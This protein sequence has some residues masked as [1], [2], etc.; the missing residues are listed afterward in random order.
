MPATQL[1][2]EL[3]SRAQ[4]AERYGISTKTIDRAAVAGDLRRVRIGSA[5]R[6]R[7]DDLAD[8]IE[9]HTETAWV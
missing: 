9:R 4:V 2:P 5:V 7:A 6:F 3:L 1:P 8:W